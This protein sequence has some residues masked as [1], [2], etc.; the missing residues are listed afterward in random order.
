MPCHTFY[1]A[2]ILFSQGVNCG[3]DDAARMV[4][5]SLEREKRGKKNKSV[6][7]FARRG[8]YAKK[9]SANWRRW[10]WGESAL[11][12]RAVVAFKLCLSRT[13]LFCFQANGREREG[14]REEG[15]HK[16][17]ANFF[18]YG[19]PFSAERKK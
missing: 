11:A 6:G 19:N 7:L 8:L 17:S 15:R 3:D 5:G 1:S 10:R 4:I 9:F 16:K 12:S 2:F 14:G 13:S 18:F